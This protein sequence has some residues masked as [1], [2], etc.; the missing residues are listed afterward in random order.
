MLSI[1]A[2]D[3]IF[4]NVSLA[5][6]T[7][8]TISDAYSYPAVDL[9]YQ[10]TDLV[11]GFAP[12]VSFA[13]LRLAWGQVGVRPAAHRFETLAESGFSY[14]TYSDPI[15][16]GQWGGGYRVDNNK[17]NDKLK[18]EVKTETELGAD[19][20]FLE[21]RFSFGFTY[22]SNEINDMLISRT[23]SPTSGYSSQYANAAKMS[24]KGIEFDGSFNVLS[25]QSSSLELKIEANSSF[26]VLAKLKPSTIKSLISCLLYTSPSPRDRG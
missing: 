21:D 15:S 11:R 1:D 12:F 16:V 2:L 7:H 3:Q 17:G 19:F 4:L 9:A 8:S 22:Y 25:N 26:C 13:K 23:L 6:E 24:N 18:P 10:A 14:S 20:R 5:N